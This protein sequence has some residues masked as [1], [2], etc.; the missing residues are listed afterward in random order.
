MIYELV[1][2]SAPSGLRPGSSGYCTVQSSRGIAAPT[3]DLL[4][5]LSGY[6]HVFTPGTP[7]ASRNPVNFGHYLLRISGRTEHVLSRVSDCELDYS[8]RSNKL[9]HHV[10]V[11]SC[12]SI[13]AGPAWLLGYEGWMVD[14]W[15]GTVCYLETLRE[16]P[17]ET[18]PQAPCFAWQQAT[19]D[20]GW[21]G[22]LA[23]AFLANPK[24]KTFVIYEP[25]TN[26]LALFDEAISLLPR[27]R[28][29]DVT[30]T[31]YGAAMPATVDCAWTGLVAGSKDVQLS[32]RFVDAL[33]IDLTAPLELATGGRLVEM[34]RTGTVAPP[35]RRADDPAT[36]PPP[37]PHT[38]AE[39][40]DAPVRLAEQR[41]DEPIVLRPLP[42][43]RPAPP[44]LARRPQQPR[45]TFLWYLVG[46]AAVC[47]VVGLATT[48]VVVSQLVPQLEQVAV[49]DAEPAGNEADDMPDDSRASEVRTSKEP[50]TPAGSSETENRELLRTD[51]ESDA[52]ETANE[53]PAGD[54]SEETSEAGTAVVAETTPAEGA[55]R[56]SV[57]SEA[58]SKPE[59]EPEPVVVEEPPVPEV[60]YALQPTDVTSEE[61]QMLELPDGW[62]R[63]LGEIQE[64][65]VLLP[66]TEEEKQWEGIS[67]EL[68]TLDGGT[69]YEV[70]ITDLD[71]FDDP[72]S[73]ARVVFSASKSRITYESRTQSPTRTHDAVLESMALLVR[74]AEGSRV[75]AVRSPQ[76]VT[77]SATGTKD[78]R[79]FLVQYDAQ[80]QHPLRLLDGFAWSADQIT[81]G[82]HDTEVT[83]RP[84]KRLQPRQRA[85]LDLLLPQKVVPAGTRIV[86]AR[87]A[88]APQKRS[89][90]IDASLDPS[91]ES[92]ATLRSNAQTKRIGI[93]EW[94]NTFKRFTKGNDA[95]TLDIDNID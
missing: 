10:V 84:A 68:H 7:E 38:P 26:V 29:W 24:R 4:E 92:I 56:D 66:V 80:T 47:L 74:G 32:R 65:R 48:W 53:P 34:A 60:V 45:S 52:A 71:E 59:P 95:S 20:A 72:F 91:P 1:Y 41:G 44:P 78:G 87:C 69:A 8:G 57:A 89:F 19:G 31:T 58:M 33:R 64:V 54:M 88:L 15:D 90:R 18:R 61:P 3:V 82:I 28:R 77:L 51:R 2:T 23:E 83:T 94:W 76:S 79:R 37:H 9:A 40:A 14:R 21:G 42:S 36:A 49:I 86:K 39:G 25:G 73:I 27:E 46:V 63:G 16:P 55:S 70:D 62:D 11:D 75:L 67:F 30:F 50:K 81:F 17:E 6:R 12:D 13:P 5:S 35:P 85:S 22:V 43:R 93:E